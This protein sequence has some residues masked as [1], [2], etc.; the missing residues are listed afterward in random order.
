M[1]TQKSPEAVTCR[2]DSEKPGAGGRSR[3]GDSAGDSSAGVRNPAARPAGA[4]GIRQP[5]TLASPTR[6]GNVH[7]GH[8]RNGRLEGCSGGTD[9]DPGRPR[10]C[11]LRELRTSQVG[12][13]LRR[14]AAREPEV[15]RQLT[16][17][18]RG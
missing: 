17:R 5:G 10:T 8:R 9:R 2:L 7:S 11:K 15:Y 18:K 13:S 6:R 4:G 12:P 1:Q 3:A 14:A 16:S